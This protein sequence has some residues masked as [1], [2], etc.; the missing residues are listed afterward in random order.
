[1]ADRWRLLAQIPSSDFNVTGIRELAAAELTLD[2]H[3]EARALE[4]ECLHAPLGRRALIEQ[5]LEDAPANARGA[6]IGPQ[7][8][9]ELDAIAMV[10]PSGVFSEFEKQHRGLLGGGA[11]VGT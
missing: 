7:D 11:T 2:D 1:L 6:L 9:T 3:L 10:I 4:M 8:H 5:P